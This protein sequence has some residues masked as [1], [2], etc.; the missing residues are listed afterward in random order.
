MQVVIGPPGCGRTALAKFLTYSGPH[1]SS[2]NFWHY[3]QL[4][5]NLTDFG[6]LRYSLAQQLLDYINR[7]P[8]LLQHVRASQRQMLANTLVEEL[9]KQSVLAQVET[10]LGNAAWIKQATE[11]QKP[12]WRKVGTTQLA[13]LVQAV[14]TAPDIPRITDTQWMNNLVTAFNLFDFSGVR[15]LLDCN[16]EAATSIIPRL[17]TL[18]EWQKFGLITTLFIPGNDVNVTIAP[19][20]SLNWTETQ[21]ERMFRHR[22]KK[23]AEDHLSPLELFQG[24]SVYNSFLQLAADQTIPLPPTPRKLAQMWQAALENVGKKERIDLDVLEQAKRVMLRWLE[25][26]RLSSP[27]QTINLKRLANLLNETFNDNELRSLCFDLDEDYDNI[28][29]QTK[30]NKIEELVQKLKRQGRLPELMEQYR[31]LRPKRAWQ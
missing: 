13:L 14:E 12:I 6:R 25:E 26:T 19:K 21:L 16:A 15:L 9:T 11:K 22:L 23:L 10:A 17:P 3:E 31:R 2:P 27:E 20:L 30:R 18:Q 7:K 5:E 1:A 29:G 4:H 28:D 8:T 24:E